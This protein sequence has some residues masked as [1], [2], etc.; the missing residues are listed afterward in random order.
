MICS[1]YSDE[2]LGEDSRKSVCIEAS[3]CQL[4]RGKEE[5]GEEAICNCHPVNDPNT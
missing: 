2:I 1:F 4:L 3:N 5:D